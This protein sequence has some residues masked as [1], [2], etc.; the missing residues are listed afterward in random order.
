MAEHD[1]RPAAPPR[2]PEIN[3]SATRSPKTYLDELVRHEFEVRLKNVEGVAAYE[4]WLD[5]NC[6]GRRP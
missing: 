6:G 1:A 3:S 2:V 4:L 5:P